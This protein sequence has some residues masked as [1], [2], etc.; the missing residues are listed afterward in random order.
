MISYCEIH[1][2]SVI[3]TECPEIPDIVHGSVQTTDGNNFGSNATVTCESGFTLGDQTHFL[4]CQ[5]NKTWSAVF[6]VCERI[7]RI[8]LDCLIVSIPLGLSI[9]SLIVSINF[10]CI[11]TSFY[12]R[13][14]NVF[15]SF[16]I[17]I[18]GFKYFPTYIKYGLYKA[19]SLEFG[20]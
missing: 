13:R 8:S 17:L 3:Y 11:S 20:L 2:F 12:L 5:A 15:F 14:F 6:P 9:V 19:L 10:L 1:I 7:G 18:I 4:R 16:S